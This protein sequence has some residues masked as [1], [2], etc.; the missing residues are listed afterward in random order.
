MSLI[1]TQPPAAEP[2]ALADL[3]A[4]LKVEGPEEDGL[5]QSV[6]AAARA[7][8]EALTGRAFVTQGWRIR[9]DAWPPAGRMALPI[10]PIASLD[11]V[12]VE[13]A[14][15]TV[16]VP[17]ARFR[18]DGAALPP[19]LGWQPGSLPVPGLPLAGIAIDVTAGF[20][21]PDAVPPALVQAVRLLA[22]YWFDNRSLVTVGHEVAVMPRMVADLV[23]PFVARRLA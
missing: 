7:H 5:I 20:G 17:L 23:A 3:K 11:A 10:G 13:T 12:T 2:L 1:L 9:R 19:R 21:A 4:F 22:A 6:A 8:L 18:L 15:G 16:S 14:A